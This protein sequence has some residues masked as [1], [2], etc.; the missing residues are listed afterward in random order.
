MAVKEII[1]KEIVKA[2][3]IRDTL[4]AHGADWSNVEGNK[5]ANHLPNYFTSQSKINM[6]SKRKPVC[7]EAYFHEDFDFPKNKM[8]DEIYG[9]KMPTRTSLPQIHQMKY[10]YIMPKKGG[11]Y[12]L[13]LADFTGYNANAADPVD[14]KYGDEFYVNT[15]TYIHTFPV[16]G[17]DYQIGIS[18]LVDEDITGGRVGLAVDGRVLTKIRSGNTVEFQLGDVANKGDTKTVTILM[19][20]KPINGGTSN[21]WTTL[22]N[23]GVDIKWIPLPGL[24]GME[25]TF[26]IFRA[27]STI[28]DGRFISGPY[29]LYGGLL[30]QDDDPL[31]IYGDWF[32]GGGEIPQSM[33]DGTLR[34]AIRKYSWITGGEEESALIQFN[35]KKQ[36]NIRDDGS[37]EVYFGFGALFSGYEPSQFEERQLYGAIHE[38]VFIQG[39]GWMLSASAIAF[40]TYYLRKRGGHG[41]LEPDNPNIADN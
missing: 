35:P 21:S 41:G 9:I 26:D 22:I 10:E 24:I 15:T 20:D 33:I 1:P 17:G 7:N 8:P 25:K 30:G 11:A 29:I 23:V 36:L 14:V 16:I 37:W 40:T 27:P 12:P 5:S 19:S 6:W 18:D 39:H 32:E 34:Y 4:I 28:G 38:Y 3:D 31:K 13:R 2:V